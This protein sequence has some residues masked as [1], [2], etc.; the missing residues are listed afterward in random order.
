MTQPTQQ[1]FPRGKMALLV[2]ALLAA[3]SLGFAISR[4][5]STGGETGMGKGPVQASTTIDTLEAQTRARPDDANA[6]HKLGA[7]LFQEGRFGDA[8]QALGNAARLDPEAAQLWSALGEARVMASEHDPM[9]DAALTAFRKAVALDP[10][11]PRARYFLAVERDL[12]GDHDGAL[13]DWLSLLEETPVD[14]PWRA[15]LIRTIEQVGKINGI[16]VEERLKR[17][18]AQSPAAP[19]L[20]TGGIPGPSAADLAAASKIPPGEQ[21]QMAQGM[22][23]SLERRLERDPG[24]IEGWIMLVRSRMTLGE[25]KRAKQALDDAIAANPKSAGLLRQQA[26]SLGVR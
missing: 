2:A 4:D 23:A 11:D 24:N 18:G 16:N 15:D 5:S 22:V 3:V 7:F 21:R 26:E 12:S 1:S 19:G 8:A 14:A 20:A 9:P 17:A 6:W 13:S 10:L 25:P